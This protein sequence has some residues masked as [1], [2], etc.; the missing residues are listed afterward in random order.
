M[1]RARPRIPVMHVDQ[2]SALLKVVLFLPSERRPDVGMCPCHAMLCMPGYATGLNMSCQGP[3][4]SHDYYHPSHMTTGVRSA[5][6]AQS[7]FTLATVKP[8]GL[9][10][11]RSENPSSFNH[12]R[13]MHLRRRLCESYVDVDGGGRIGRR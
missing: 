6:P 12:R 8:R 13:M 5:T 4:E 7:L 2:T 3:I 10:L 11:H 1:A 9:D